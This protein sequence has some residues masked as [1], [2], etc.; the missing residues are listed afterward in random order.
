MSN[1]DPDELRRL[2]VY[3]MCEICRGARDVRATVFTDQ[4][5]RFDLYCPTCD[6]QA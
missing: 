2:M 4:S 3:G 5:K 1:A 6:D